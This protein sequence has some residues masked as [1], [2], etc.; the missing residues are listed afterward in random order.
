[1]SVLRPAPKGYEQISD[2]SAAVSLTVPAGADFAL[3]QA[4]AANV[5]WRDD[6]TAP[7]ATVGVQLAAGSTLAYDG[8]L[9]A[10]QLIEES[11]GAEVNVAYYQGGE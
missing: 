9:S 11:A 7:T 8:D 1:M 3:I 10:I 5:R 2:V 6:G 4:L